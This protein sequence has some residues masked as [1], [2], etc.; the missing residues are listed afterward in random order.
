ME[1]AFEIILEALWTE[2]EKQGFA[3]AKKY[4]DEKGPA[5]MFATEEVC[6]GVVYNKNRQSFVLQSNAFKEDGSFAHEWKQLAVWLFDENE[7]TA[8][9]ATSI[10]N[11]FTEVVMGS[12]RIAAV[13]NAKK[14]TRK[15]GDDENNIDPLFFFNRLVGII[16]ELK[17][18]MN[19][20]RITYGKIRFATL[21]KKSIAPKIEELGRNRPNSDEFKKFKSLVNDMYKNG[22]PDLRAIITHGLL[23]NIKDQ[24]VID[25]VTADFEDGLS[26]VYKCSRKLMDKNIKPEKVKKQKK[27]VAAAL[28]N[29][30]RR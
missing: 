13:Q 12:R 23:N 15:K 26:K 27:I 2:L 4:D 10:A 25:A 8:A 17:D 6:Y 1:K 16:P 14:R 18:E 11:D 29:A 28:E 22:D 3:E 21:T 9:D 19:K 5:Y 7:G 24:A 20:D 30:N